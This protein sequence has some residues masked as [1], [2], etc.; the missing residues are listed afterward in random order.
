MQPFDSAH[1]PHL[2]RAREIGLA[3][4]RLVGLNK[5]GIKTHKTL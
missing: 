4:G 3:I 1:C 5:G 2:V